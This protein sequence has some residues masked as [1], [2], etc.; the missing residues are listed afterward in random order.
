MLE[1]ATEKRFRENKKEKH[2]QNAENGWYHYTTHFAVP[3]YINDTKTENYNIY[4]ACLLIN[5]AK[6]G[7]LYLYDLIDIKKEASTPLTIS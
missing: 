1:I 2:S 5:H 7:K 6:N 3:I 4:S